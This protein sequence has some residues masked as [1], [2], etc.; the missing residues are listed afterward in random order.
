MLGL[1]WAVLRCS[2]RCRACLVPFIGEDFFPTVDAGTFRLHVRTPPGTRIEEVEHIFSKWRR[3]FARR[4]RQDEL[5]MVLDDIG[6]P[7][8]SFN[9]AFGDG[10]LTDVQDGEISGVAE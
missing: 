3:R 4:F 8:G 7:N 10:S 6:I 5:A 1:R 9:L 2:W